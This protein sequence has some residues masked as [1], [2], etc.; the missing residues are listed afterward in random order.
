MAAAEPF[1][2]FLTLAESIS[3]PASSETPAQASWH[4]LYGVLISVAWG[5]SSKLLKLSNSNLLSCLFS[6]PQA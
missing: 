6:L 4:P 3:S 1:A 2:T 5:L